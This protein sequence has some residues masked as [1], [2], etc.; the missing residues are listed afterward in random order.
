MAQKALFLETSTGVVSAKTLSVPEIPLY[1]YK[2]ADTSRAS[3]TTQTDDPHLVINLTA[4]T[5]VVQVNLGAATSSV[6]IKAKWAFS[7]TASGFIYMPNDSQVNDV[8]ILGDNWY[9]GSATNRGVYGQGVVT[10]TA[11]GNLSLQWAQ[12]SSNAN[13]SII[14]QNSSLFASKVA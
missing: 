1:V 5:W 9:I 13:A 10:V 8:G 11:I 7:G 6:P 2:S 12:N 4:G 3:T 14:K